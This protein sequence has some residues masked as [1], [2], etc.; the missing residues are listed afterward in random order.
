MKISIKTK[1]KISP[2]KP[3]KINRG[4]KKLV[5]QSIDNNT[6]GISVFKPIKLKETGFTVELDFWAIF[7]VKQIF[8]KFKHLLKGNKESKV[9]TVQKISKLIRPIFFENKNYK[10]QTLIFRTIIK[11]MNNE[12]IKS[13]LEESKKNNFLEHCYKSID[14]YLE[15]KKNI[16]NQIKENKISK[17][18]IGKNPE[19]KL[20]TLNSKINNKFRVKTT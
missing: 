5:T 20:I 1:N 16:I 7:F 9:K 19:T 11:N 14:T 8:N 18:C 12:V 2:L 15:T 17:N 6:I 4:K 3:K 13:I 10:M